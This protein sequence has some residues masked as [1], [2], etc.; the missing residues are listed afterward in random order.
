MWSS[1]LPICFKDISLALLLRVRVPMLLEC[2]NGATA[3][4]R[5]RC[6]REETNRHVALSEDV[7]VGTFALSKG[8]S[9][10]ALKTYAKRQHRRKSA[11]LNTKQ[12]NGMIKFAKEAL[13]IGWR[14][15]EL[16]ATLHSHLKATIGGG[17]FAGDESCVRWRIDYTKIMC[18]NVLIWIYLECNQLECAHH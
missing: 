13:R 8:P 17:A 7:F 16:V 6:T 18:I 3:A 15:N 5:F 2:W 11:K 12:V 10:K 1:Y 14:W 4:F 9:L